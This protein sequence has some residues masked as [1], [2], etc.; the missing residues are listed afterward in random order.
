MAASTLENNLNALEY[1]MDELL[2]AFQGRDA[3]QCASTGDPFPKDEGDQTKPA[4][5]SH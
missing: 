1:K 4:D 3:P 2:Q 5:S